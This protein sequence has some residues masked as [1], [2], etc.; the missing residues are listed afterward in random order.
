MSEPRLLRP[1]Y[2]A[3]ERAAHFAEGF[4]L[5]N[6]GEF[7]EAHERFEDLWRSNRPEPRDLFQGLVQVAAGLHHLERFDRVNSCRRLFARARRRLAD[8]PS[9]CCGLD[10]EALRADLETWHFWLE[11]PVEPRPGRPLLRRAGP[12]PLS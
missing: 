11:L 1:D 9:P 5:F 4:D 7:F 2:T 8:L 6:R 10:L 3:S 12:A